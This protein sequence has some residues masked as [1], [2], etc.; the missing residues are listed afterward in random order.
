VHY[1]YAPAELAH[2]DRL[3]VDRRLEFLAG[4]FAAKEAVLKALGS[5]LLQGIAPR[6]ICVDRATTGAPVVR[7]TGGA[8]GLPPVAVSI[9][10]KQNVVAAIA[11]RTREETMTQ[12][13]ATQQPGTTACL[14]LRIG[15]EEGHY[16][17]GLVDGA[18]VLKLFGDVLT[19]I[20]IRTD[21]DE[22]LLSEYSEVKFLAPVRTGDYIEARG[23]VVRSTR[24]R[25]V[26]E[27]T[28]H[29]VIAARPDK[30]E[31]V[32]EV[33]DEPELVCKATATTVV[34]RGND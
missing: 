20:T 15:G 23:N 21:S 24:L 22:G 34:P 3:A 7:F 11:I 19:E 28:A 32:A 18:R 27:L 29:K 8:K 16:G 14:R 1:S 12:Q 26:V 33:L 4:R 25:R 17:G 9:T 10:H 30:G 5:G 2:A 31:T 6:D 13:P